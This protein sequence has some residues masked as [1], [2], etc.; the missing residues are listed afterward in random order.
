MSV[1]IH[2]PDEIEHALRRRASAVG[3]DIT[4]FVTKIVTE[5]LADEPEVSARTESH[6][7]YMTRVRD[8]I[9]RHG[10]DNGRFDDSRESIYAGRGE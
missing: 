2:F 7:E 6:E 8:I 9:R 1:S 3:Q 4:T 10:I 5:Q